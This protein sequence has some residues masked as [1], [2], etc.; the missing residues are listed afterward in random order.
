MNA[1]DSSLRG[2]V[3]RY[4][5]QDEYEQALKEHQRRE[6]LRGNRNP[7]VSA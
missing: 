4:A 3:E 7:S 6:E 5:A 2:N 1:G